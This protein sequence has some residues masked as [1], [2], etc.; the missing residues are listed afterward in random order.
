MFICLVMDQDMSIGKKIQR[1]MS[2]F[3]LLDIHH[4]MWDKTAMTSTSTGTNARGLE[5]ATL[6]VRL[7]HCFVICTCSPLRVHKSGR[8]KW[9][10]Y[11]EHATPR[12]SRWPHQGD[13]YSV[14]IPPCNPYHCSAICPDQDVSSSYVQQ[15]NCHQPQWICDTAI[16]MSCQNNIGACG[17]KSLTDLGRL[18]RTEEG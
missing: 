8:A 13:F 18:S 5:V 15:R 6:Q 3:T 17:T 2:P 7:I 14:P 9:H 1:F 16:F 10:M 4:R 12:E 11:S